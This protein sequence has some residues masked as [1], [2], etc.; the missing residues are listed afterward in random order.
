MEKPLLSDCRSRGL[1]IAGGG[2]RNIDRRQ[3]QSG[4][5]PGINRDEREKNKIS[6]QRHRGHRGNRCCPSLRPLCPLRLCVENFGEV[7]AAKTYAA[8]SSSRN[9]DSAASS[10][11][12]NCPPSTA[13]QN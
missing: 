13:S 10:K 11:C 12:S 8:R 6:T 2:V 7:F 3:T 4:L 5:L 9:I 1:M